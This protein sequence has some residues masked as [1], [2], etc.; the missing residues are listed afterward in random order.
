MKKTL[1]ITIAIMLISV[2]MISCTAEPEPVNEPTPA[3]TE[4]V[5]AEP[6][7]AQAEPEPEESEPEI[8]EIELVTPINAPAD[9][10]WYER[11][12]L[13][14][15]APTDTA[16]EATAVDPVTLD[17]LVGINQEIMPEVD[18]YYFYEQVSIE[19]ETEEEIAEDI[20]DVTADEPIPDGLPCFMDPWELF[21]LEDGLNLRAYGA[22]YTFDCETG[23]QLTDEP[24]EG[25][26]G[27]YPVSVAIVDGCLVY[28]AAP[29]AQMIDV[30][31]EPF[32]VE[33]VAVV[34]TAQDDVKAD[35]IGSSNSGSGNSG[36]SG[37][38]G[39]SG[40]GSSGESSTGG[41]NPAPSQVPS[42]PVPSTPEP[43]QPQPTATLKPPEPTKTPEPEEPELKPCLVCWTCGEVFAYGKGNHNQA[44]IDHGN[45]H[46]DRG[47]YFSYYT[48]WR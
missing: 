44:V 12:T 6:V 2:F 47:E 28:Y 15:Y 26:E 24:I 17:Y 10:Q 46:M 25:T 23:E 33:E 35:S 36:N 48:D 22:K 42:N 9:F 5:Q 13:I 32:I 19:D 31:T 39:N 18:V 27:V 41:G 4:E 21:D 11:Y 8:T 34:D 40:S 7:A 1:I 30:E 29:D 20:E 16:E 38:T 37:N 43:Q 3:D 14:E 45:Y